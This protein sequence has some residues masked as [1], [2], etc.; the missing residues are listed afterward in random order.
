MSAY[1][2]S[3]IVKISHSSTPYDHTSLAVLYTRSV[4]L[5]GRTEFGRLVKAP[6]TIRNQ[7]NQPMAAGQ[8]V[9]TAGSST[10]RDNFGDGLHTRDRYRLITSDEPHADRDPR[11][12]L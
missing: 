7:Y 5:S 1:G 10:A 8:G 6:F 4:M 11:G 12:Y 9:P 2:F 3:A